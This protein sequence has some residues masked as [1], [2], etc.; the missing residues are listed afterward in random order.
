MVLKYDNLSFDATV[1]SSSTPV[2]LLVL[3]F[4]FVNAAKL[5]MDEG[6]DPASIAEIVVCYLSSDVKVFAS[7]HTG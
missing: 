3:R 5:L 6:I 1:H 4:R 2:S 7:Y